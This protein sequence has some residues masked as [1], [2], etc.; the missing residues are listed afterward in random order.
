MSL[1]PTVALA[2]GY[3][4]SRLIKGGWH[5][6][7]GHGSI[8]RGQALRD[9]AAFVESG[10]TTFDCADIYTGVEELIGEFR[11]AYP[12]LAR[13][14]QIHTKFVPDLD[15]LATI[16]A[17]EVESII[18]R[19]LR[20]LGVETLDLVQFHWW[21]YALPRHVEIALEL[22]RLRRG[23]K[24][25]HIGLTNFD[26]EH[27]QQ[28]VE[29][30]VPV[31]SHQVQYSLLDERPSGAMAEYCAARGIGLLCY[32]T[33][34]GGF[35]SNAWLGRLAPTELANRSL[36][37]YRLIIEEFGGWELFQQLLEVLQHVALRHDVDIASV[38][39]RFVLDQRGV[40]AAIVGATSTAHLAQHRTIAELTLSS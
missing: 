31:V 8:D 9:M 14:V 10:I 1:I 19:S 15:R 38:A 21:D 25:R 5:L 11:A 33:V 3:R 35:L 23:G 27:L 24:I 36:T 29:G 20:R 6:A 32:G 22:E 2:S 28:I 13:Q 17:A 34:A 12:T 40:A 39:T 4:I 16:G 30:G 7:G 37:K 18:D 26:L